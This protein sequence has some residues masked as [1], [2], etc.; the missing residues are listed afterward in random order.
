MSLKLTDFHNKHKD[1]DIYIIASGKSLDYIDESFFNN[2]I[3]IGVNQSYKKI[4]TQYLVRKENALL[5]EIIKNDTLKNIIHFVSAG[6]C[7]GLN[8]QNK[9]E[10]DKLSDEY[11]QN[12]CIYGHNKNTQN[13]TS[14]PELR[15][16]QLFVSYSTITTA[17]Y[18]AYYMG[19]KNIIL[20]GHDCG[21][22]NNESNFNGY[23]TKQTISIAWK[24]DSQNK[25]NNWLNVIENDTI[26]LK[27]YLNTKNV[28]VLSLNPF[29]N[30]NL[31][32]HIYSNSKNKIN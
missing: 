14:I 6:N 27:K 18:L 5:L 20:V 1:N 15:N 10:I 26:I 25:Y 7:G 30:F 12:I 21:L 4:I 29:I 13:I 8:L 3:C 22:I 24:G 28:N 9:K 23:H 11:K 32:G 19:A 17:I 2:K 31:E 16:N